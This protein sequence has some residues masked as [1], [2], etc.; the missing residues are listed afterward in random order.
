[1]IEDIF[2]TA[3]AVS[4]TVDDV[5]EAAGVNQDMALE[6]TD[7][8]N[9]KVETLMERYGVERIRRSSSSELYLCGLNHDD[10]QVAS[11]TELVL[12][13]I[14]IVREL[15]ESRTCSHPPTPT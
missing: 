15:G 10:A 3:T 12:A 8:L 4:I 5:P 1:V 14:E 7:R 11:A 6:I 9:E 13:V 2:D